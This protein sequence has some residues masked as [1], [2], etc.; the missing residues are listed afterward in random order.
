[1]RCALYQNRARS[2][3]KVAVPKCA[4]RS[5]S[6][7]ARN[8]YISSLEA[9]CI[10]CVRPVCVQRAILPCRSRMRDATWF[11][12]KVEILV[13]YSMPY[14]A[15]VCICM[16]CVCISPPSLVTYQNSLMRLPVKVTK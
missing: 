8:A 5:H 15:L 1:M 3:W 16:L 12:E 7:R 11:L 10:A 13:Q 2:R 4:F 9:Q 14:S 6:T